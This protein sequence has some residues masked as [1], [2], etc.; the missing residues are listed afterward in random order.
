MDLLANDVRFALRT[1][2][3]QPAFTAAVVATLAL[4]I[5]A[6]TAIFSVVEAT[7]LRPLP[8]RTPDQIA[9]LWGVAGPQR[10]VR[11]AS[12]IEAQDWA[13]LNHTFE[14][15]AIY[16]ETSLNLRTTDGA[17]RVDAEMVSASYFPMLGATAQV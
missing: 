10:A 15:L 13:R 16:D 7:L 4:A 8:F 2:L 9:F 11:G 17:E 14:N 5:G 3:K 1:L 6:S 12:F